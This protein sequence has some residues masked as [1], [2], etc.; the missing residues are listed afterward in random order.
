MQIKNYTP[1]PINVTEGPLRGSYPSE[2]LA[3]VDGLPLGEVVG[4]PAPVR[5]VRYVVSILVAER[6]PDRDDLLVPGEQV[7]DAAGRIVGCRS[8]I[9]P[10][11]SSPALAR[12]DDAGWLWVRQVKH[13]GATLIRMPSHCE[14]GYPPGVA[15]AVNKYGSHVGALMVFNNHEPMG[16]LAA[17][18]FQVRDAAAEFGIEVREDHEVFYE[19]GAVGCAWD[20]SNAQWKLVGVD[21]FTLN[22]DLASLRFDSQEQAWQAAE[23]A[24]RGP[25][26]E[27]PHGPAALVAVV[28]A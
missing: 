21:G 1:H 8:L 22:E 12:L 9:S 19:V 26:A 11:Q 18:L 10:H 28:S 2:G 4:L 15:V 6:L 13:C 16:P 24:I 23:R 14:I 25:G 3:R 17:K 20:Q 27:G 5:G 7:R